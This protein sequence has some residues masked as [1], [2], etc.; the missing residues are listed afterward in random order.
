M[1]TYGI[2]LTTTMQLEQVTK[3]QAKKEWAAKNNVYVK[4]SPKMWFMTNCTEDPE[5]ED[6]EYGIKYFICV[7]VDETKLIVTRHANIAEYFKSKGINAKVVEYAIPS[8]VYGKKLY[9][10]TMP[11]HLMSF[12]EECYILTVENTTDMNF[13]SIPYTEFDNLGVTI[14]KY[15]VQAEKVDLF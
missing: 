11:V 12:A 4:I 10:G 5:F 3:A 9:G 13:E 14:K 6:F 1:R 2:D 15:T 8:D 7:P